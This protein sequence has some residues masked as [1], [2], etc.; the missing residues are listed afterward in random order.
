[1]HLQRPTIVFR[2]VIVLLLCGLSL[3]MQPAHAAIKDLAKTFVAAATASV[4]ADSYQA[5]TSADLNKIPAQIAEQLGLGS[6]R[7]ITMIR[8]ASSYRGGDLQMLESWD[9]L[10]GGDYYPARGLETRYVDGDYYLLGPVPAYGAPQARWYVEKNYGDYEANFQMHPLKTMLEFDLGSL[11]MNGT[12]TLDSK[13]CSIYSY[14]NIPLLKKSIGTLLDSPFYD[15]SRILNPTLAVSVC[16]DNYV[17]RLRLTFDYDC[18]C[19]DGQIQGRDDQIVLASAPA[20]PALVMGYALE[21][22]YSNYGKALIID[23][24]RDAIPFEYAEDDS[25]YPTAI[26]FNGGNIRTEPSKRGSVLGQLHAGE[27]VELLERTA[28]GQ[29]YLV[30][31][32]EATGWVSSTLLTIPKGLADHVPITGSSGSAVPQSGSNAGL[33]ARVYNGGNV[34][35]EPNT[36][37]MVLDQINAGEGV[38]L[39]ARSGEWYQITNIR[40]VTGWVHRSL[41]TVD[42]AVAQQ[43]P[44]IR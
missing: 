42:P 6:R 29:W 9:P 18:G 2:I 20:G 40:G 25:Y 32:P 13:N 22:H 17:H 7:S 27:T 1:M 37:G 10:F 5:S 8:M 28:N 41:L 24:P 19:R 35:T 12:E 33:Q 3:P 23:A 43:V 14:R 21:W 16:E 4:Q 15:T 44:L 26:V 11:T 39:L 36:R 30:I 34:R 31:A 38:M